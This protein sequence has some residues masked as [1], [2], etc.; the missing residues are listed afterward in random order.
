LACKCIRKLLPVMIELLILILLRVQANGL[1]H[2][3]FHPSSPLTLLP[4]VSKLDKVQTNDLATTTF[5]PSPMPIMYPH[6][7]EH[8]AVQGK[9]HTCIENAIKVCK[10][11]W[12][13]YRLS[14]H[15][16]KN[17]IA[18]SFFLRGLC[19]RK[20]SGESTMGF[21]NIGCIGTCLDRHLIDL[22]TCFKQCYR[23]HF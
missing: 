10:E 22:E 20:Q 12:P 4:H 7:S 18:C 8:D 19:W 13:L 6:F 17:V 3:S 1:A 23:S 15:H 9:K 16:L 2:I 14:R 11:P 5:G 21:K